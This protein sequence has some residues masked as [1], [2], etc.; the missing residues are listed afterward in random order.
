MSKNTIEF[1][2]F[3]C[4]FGSFNLLDRFSEVIYPS[5]FESTYTR[6]YGKTSYFLYKPELVKL[7]DDDEA[8]A[9]VGRFV[10]METLEREQRFDGQYLVSDYAELE[11]APSSIFA[12]LLRNHRLIYLKENRGSPGVDTFGTTMESFFKNEQKKYIK[13]NLELFKEL[14]P[15]SRIEIRNERSRLEE[16]CPVPEVSVVSLVKSDGDIGDFINSFEKIESLALK[17]VKLNDEI[18]AGALF[19]SIR[20]ASSGLE[21]QSAS[22]TFKDSKG[23]VTETA[24]ELIEGAIEDQNVQ[25]SISGKDRTGGKLSRKNEDVNFRISLDDEVFSIKQAARAMYRKFQALLN[26]NIFRAPV[27]RDEGVIQGKLNEIKI[28]YYPPEDIN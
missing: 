28:R 6:Q 8:L 27:M 17:V 14:E 1:A 22:L 19:Q 3:I 10:K 18:D 5:I 23:V 9:I 20:K 15:R 13:K 4:H 21:V 7:S 24:K 26:N 12:L 11:N 16:Y 25:F 2:N